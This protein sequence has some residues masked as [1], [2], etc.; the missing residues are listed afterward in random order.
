M[1]NGI[2]SLISCSDIS[3]LMYRSAT[4]FRVL[5]LYPAT[6]LNSLMSSSSFLVL[7]LG[8]SIY[9][10]MSFANSDL[11]FLFQLGFLLFLSLL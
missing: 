7:S 3:L 4:D 1:V 9:S 10:I 2:V 11:L 8:F 6:L 5:I